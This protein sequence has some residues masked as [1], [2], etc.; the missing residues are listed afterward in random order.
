M[1]QIAR[2]VRQSGIARAY[3]A[4]IVETLAADTMEDLKS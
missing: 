1:K 2:Q 4:D 3:K